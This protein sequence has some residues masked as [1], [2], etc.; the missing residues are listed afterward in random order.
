M[1]NKQGNHT[2]DTQYRIKKTMADVL[3]LLLK[4]NKQYGDSATKPAKIFSKLGAVESICCR[5][6][7]K[8]MRIKNKGINENTL[9]T[10]DDLIGYLVL[11]KIAIKDENNDK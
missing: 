11:L 1:T 8:M 5:I 2:G 10:I 4:K 3:S 6:D 9:D 7:D